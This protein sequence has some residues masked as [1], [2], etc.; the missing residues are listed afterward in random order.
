MRLSATFKNFAGN[1]AD[2]TS[3]T[4]TIKKVGE[5]AETLTPVA[6]AVGHYSYDYTPLTAGTYN[7]RF[8]GTGAIVAAV[9][10]QF[11]VTDP[12]TA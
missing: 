8:N 11:T 7:Y 2:P 12:I 3:V 5:S 10:G 9:Q 6:G 1:F 4:L